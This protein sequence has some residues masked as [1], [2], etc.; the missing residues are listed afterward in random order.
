MDKMLRKTATVLALLA[1]L[2]GIASLSSAASAQCDHHVEVLKLYCGGRTTAGWF[3]NGTSWGYYDNLPT[4]LFQL[5]VDEDTYNALCINLTVYLRER[6]TFNASKYTAE[7]TCKNNSIAYILNN[8]IIDPNHCDNVS[9]GQSAVWYFW[10][11]NE[12]FCRLGTP[13]YN[14]TATPGDPGWESNWIPDCTAHPLACL[15][16][17]SPSPRDGLLSRMPSSA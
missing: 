5:K 16:Y 3:Y 8:W 6:D 9:A 2:L 10:Y 12:T 13:Q 1:A 7:P 15:L 14:H 4:Y 11:I 17:T